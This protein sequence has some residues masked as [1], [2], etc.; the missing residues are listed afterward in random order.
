MKREFFLKSSSAIAVAVA[1]LALA[2]PDALLAGKGVEPNL[3]VQVWVREVGAL[4]FATGAV[5][6]L[7]RKSPDSLALRGVLLG[8]ETQKVLAGSRIPVLV[9]RGDS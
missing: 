9:Y 1:T 2:L 4:I 8:S 3:S 5:T 6:F 7:V